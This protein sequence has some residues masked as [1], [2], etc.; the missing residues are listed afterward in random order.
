[1]GW[2][3][4]LGRGTAKVVP[5]VSARRVDQQFRG[6]RRS[7]PCG[8]GYQG[9]RDE[10]PAHPVDEHP[11]R[12]GHRC[13][14]GSTHSWRVVSSVCSASSTICH[15]AD[16]RPSGAA[17][18]QL[19][20]IGRRRR[21][22][23]SACVSRTSAAS[24][25]AN[26]STAPHATRRRIARQRKRRRRS[27]RRRSGR[28]HA[29]LSG[30]ALPGPSRHQIHR[31]VGGLLAAGDRSRTVVVEQCRC[32]CRQLVTRSSSIANGVDGRRRGRLWTPTYSS[33][34]R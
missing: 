32:R 22:N 7:A 15:A 12:G 19:P 30:R 8:L 18:E 23:G 14:V 17:A 5:G 33:Q 4:R 16:S 3:G 9:G 24:V 2:R 13:G 11:S 27:A 28:G 21:R 29:R 31:P 20:G 26:R 1:M 34:C 25:S 10:Q 6:G